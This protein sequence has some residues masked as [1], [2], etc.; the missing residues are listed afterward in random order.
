MS[1]ESSGIEWAAASVWGGE[2]RAESPQAQHHHL[3]ADEAAGRGASDLFL[4]IEGVGDDSCLLFGETLVQ[5]L[6]AEP[7]APPAS[8]LSR[9]LRAACVR[10][11]THALAPARELIALG[12]STVLIQ[13]HGMVLAQLLPAQVYL[14]QQG[15]G[16][17]RMWPDT[18]VPAPM[19]EAFRRGQARRWDLEIEHARATPRLGATL[20]ISTSELAARLRPSHVRR[21]LDQ[22]SAEQAATW[23]CDHLARGAPHFEALVV[24][25]TP[26]ATSE[27]GWSE[28][29]ED[30]G[31]EWEEAA[32]SDAPTARPR[33]ARAAGG[34]AAPAAAGFSAM[35][36]NAWQRLNEVLQGRLRII[37]IGLAA[38]ILLIFILSRLSGAGPTQEVATSPTPNPQA[39][40]AAERAVSDLA[41]VT[42]REQGQAAVVEAL[43]KI[44]ALDERSSE[45]AAELRSA[46][47]AQSTRIAGLE[48]PPPPQPSVLSAEQI[49]RPTQ[50]S[51][52]TR[53]GDRL[54]VLDAPRAVLAVRPGEG[55]ELLLERG[56]NKAGQTVGDLAYLVATTDGVVS[57]DSTGH[58]WFLTADDTMRSGRLPGSAGWQR[59][60]GFETYQVNLYAV[61]TGANQLLRWKP[62][63]LGTYALPPDEWFGTS[64]PAEI[65]TALDLAIDGD[66]FVLAANGGITRY[67][68]G[69]PQPFTLQ[70]LERSLQNPQAITTSSSTNSLYVVD[71]GN[72]RIVQLAKG[73]QFERELV[74]V[75]SPDETI[76]DVWVD[77]AGDRIFVLT[78]QR[79]SEYVLPPEGGPTVTLT[80]VEPPAA[81]GS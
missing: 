46:V 36:A 60:L 62:T 71:T 70:G 63:A 12:T 11:E 33:P 39:L 52:V 34:R 48:P 25:T 16:T 78:E 81:Q 35:A 2:R 69:D 55:P 18:P 7:E 10:L 24:R 80:P 38:V 44:S 1:S 32:G 5:A 3:P 28:G 29:Q 51:V 19:G 26:A 23:L 67:R 47:E 65:S 66:I 53:F 59:V 9:A 6:L 72:S 40:A 49:N 76:R 30:L 45:R 43:A 68:T 61:D 14:L 27:A 54:F 15:Q 31:P 17:L 79:L 42:E 41:N 57:I 75:A 74:G 58:Y 37:L 21:A 8:A 77:E 4:V 22:D 13:E 73:G 20:L 50:F 64:V 56:G